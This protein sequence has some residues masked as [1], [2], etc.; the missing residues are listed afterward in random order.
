MSLLQKELTLV[1]HLPD[2]SLKETERIDAWL[3]LASERTPD[4]IACWKFRDL[5][6]SSNQRLVSKS[7]LCRK[8]LPI[9]SVVQVCKRS[10]SCI[11]PFH[12]RIRSV[13]KRSATPDRS[14][15]EEESM[16]NE[17]NLGDSNNVV[18]AV[19]K[20]GR[21]PS[22]YAGRN[23]KKKDK[24]RAFQAFVNLKPTERALLWA[25]LR[26][27]SVSTPLGL[28]RRQNH[29]R[30]TKNCLSFKLSARGNCGNLNIAGHV[31]QAKRAA[32]FYHTGRYPAGN[33]LC[34]CLNSFCVEPSHLVV[35]EES[36]RYQLQTLRT[37]RK[38]KQTEKYLQMYREFCDAVKADLPRQ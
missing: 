19:H 16:E 26:K 23:L 5:V 34:A 8:R 27:S 22:K 12:L 18:K 14:T 35:G 38:H 21:L 37:A 32:L 9:G 2:L 25:H 31:L 36:K 24:A 7:W 13:P 11:N 28:T 33:V 17:E 20:P 30:L 1:S 29:L 10:Q 4:E 3:A 15:S 6:P